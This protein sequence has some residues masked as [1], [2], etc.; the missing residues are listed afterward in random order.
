M[1][2]FA[3]IITLLFATNLLS[4]Q[5]FATDYP[6]SGSLLPKLSTQ[7]SSEVNGRVEQVLVSV[8]DHVKKDQP[9]LQVDPFAHEIDY[10]KQQ[11]AVSLAQL[12]YENA[13]KNFERMQNLWSKAEGENS[14]ISKKQLEDAE[15][16]LNQNK[17]Q[18]QQAQINLDNSK[19][20][21]DNTTIKAPYD[22]VITKCFVDR[23]EALLAMPGT[24]L[25]QVMDIS[26]LIFEFTV[27]QSMLGAIHPGLE[28]EA[29]LDGY[30]E[31]LI[32]SIDKV[33][34]QVDTTSRAT[35]CRAIINN[36]PEKA[37]KPGSFVTANIHLSQGN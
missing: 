33:F 16:T 11:T 2:N 26:E 32:S 7:V 30:S 28:I 27:P 4:T 8:G 5:G 12:T 6:V 15:L 20:I 1:K 31:T 3:C 34:P 19:R 21:L 23:G 18:L 36:T 35:T 25:F 29:L 37:L 10:K 14:S 17:L 13:I 22:G 24:P 9:L